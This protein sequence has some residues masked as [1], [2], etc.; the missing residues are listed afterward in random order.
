MSS[1][2]APVFG[3]ILLLAAVPDDPITV[4]LK[5]AKFQHPEAVSAELFGYS[6][7]EEKLFF[8]TNGKAELTVKLPADGDYEIIIKASCDSAQ[9]ERAK[10]KVELAGEPVGKETL[11]TTDDPSDYRFTAKGKAGEHKLTIEFTNDAFKEGEFDR[12]F[13][14]HGITIKKVQ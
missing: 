13:Y 4:D 1:L 3:T 14:V 7:G 12:N 6:D 2:L 5:A 11:L 9:N 8:Y 10:F